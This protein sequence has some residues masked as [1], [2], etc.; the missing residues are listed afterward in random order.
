MPG[1]LSLAET[2]QQLQNAAEQLAGYCTALSNEAFFWQ[3]A[4]KWSAAQQV[5]HL[6][7]ATKTAQYAFVL[8]KFIVRLAGGKPNRPSRPFDELAV[9]YQL[10][11]ARGGKASRRYV[12]KP[13][14]AGYGKER[15]I[16][17]FRTAMHRLISALQERWQEHQADA[18]IV[19]HPLLGKITL[20][21]LCYFTIFHTHHH[22]H[23]IAALTGP[24]SPG[25]AAV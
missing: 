22:L 6:V 2:A 24:L 5:K 21:E 16:R 25:S 7:T 19:P 12:P 20:R 4:G 14:A 3:P 15:L 8:P 11:L 10:K 9:N 23:S 18:Y 17:E 1:H 13:V